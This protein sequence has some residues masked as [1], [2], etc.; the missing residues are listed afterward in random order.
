M[1]SL[2]IALCR[3]KTLSDPSHRFKVRRN[4]EQMNLTGVALFHPTFALVYVEGASKFVRAYK[5]LMLHRI[6]WTEPARERGAP[7]VELAGDD[8]ADAPGPSSGGMPPPGSAKDDSVEGAVSLEGNRCDLVWEGP[9]RERNFTGFRARSCP[10][11][12]SAKEAL[13]GKL[14]GYWDMAKNWRPEEIV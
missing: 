11:D 7:D 13:G 1:S 12:G 10:T 2:L 8:D 5:R 4:A 6:A 14:T 9:I 3:V